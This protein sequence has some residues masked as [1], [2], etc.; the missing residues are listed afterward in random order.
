MARLET[1]FTDI[2]FPNPFLVSSSPSTTNARMIKK[3]FRAGWGGVVLKTVGLE[4]TPNPSPR[5]AVL[6]DG[7]YK[8]GMLN[9]ELISDLTVGQWVDELK[10]IRDAFPERPV[11]ASIMGGGR[12]ED[13]HQVIALL[14]PHGV[15]AFELNVSCPNFAHGGRGAQL[16]QDPESLATA[17]GWARE[18]TRLPV[19]VKLTPNVADVV[20]LAQ[21]AKEQGADAIVATNT[22]SG[23]AGVDLECFA[24]LPAVGGIG[25]FGGYSGPG[26]KAVA[27]R[28]AAS[29]GRSIDI[30]L[31]GCGGISSWR[32]A[33][34]YMAVGACIVQVC[35]AVMWNGYEIIEK[36][37][38]GLNEYL[39]AHGF[40]SVD[41]LVGRALPQL[42]SYPDIDLSIKLLAYVDPNKC[43]GCGLCVKACDA[44]GFEALFMQDKK[45]VVDVL[46]CD[47]CGM[48]VGICTSDGIQMVPKSD[49]PALGG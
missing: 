27:L 3:A 35:T 45:A 8:K 20:P 13:W 21:V 38:S 22:L 9:I 14:E 39:D 15:N 36:L 43:N 4:P 42:R 25:I 44:G 49:P 2:R 34:E 23:M 47:G 28:C 46:K 32:D 17:V 18:A 11:I 12:A 26:L 31:A 48:C 5:M 33:A 19:W 16:G 10:S 7:R 40:T 29:I 1:T 37:T 41:E 30:P 6:R 24:P